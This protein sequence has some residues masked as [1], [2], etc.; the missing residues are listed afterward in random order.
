MHFVTTACIRAGFCIARWHGSSRPIPSNANTAMPKKIGYCA[1]LNATKLGGFSCSNFSLSFFVRSCLVFCSMCFSAAA[2]SAFFVSGST[3]ASAGGR[4]DAAPGVA[5]A[6]ATTTADAVAVALLLVVLDEEGGP[7]PE[8]ED[9]DVP[10]AAGAAVVVVGAGVVL[11]VLGC[12]K[13]GKPATTPL[14]AFNNAFATVCSP[15]GDIWRT[16]P[17]SSVYASG[18]ST[19]R[20]GAMLVPSFSTSSDSARTSHPAPTLAAYRRV[21]I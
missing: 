11:V 6:E 1:K 7:V 14:W 12:E 18:A 21:A 16:R 3:T 15:A 9:T 13:F 8:V 20:D 2:S 5:V 19:W 10:D 4:V 17:D